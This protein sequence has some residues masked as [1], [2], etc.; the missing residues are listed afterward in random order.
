MFLL[1]DTESHKY[2][3]KRMWLDALRREVCWRHRRGASGHIRRATLRRQ[4]LSELSAGVGAGACRYQRRAA[5]AD[6][7]VWSRSGV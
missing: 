2:F 7:N 5:R 4:G 6:W 1:F 3:S